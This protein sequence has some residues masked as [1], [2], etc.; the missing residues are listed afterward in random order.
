LA[1]FGKKDN[2]KI[3]ISQIVYNGLPYI[4]LRQFFL[5]GSGEWL[6]T[7]KGLTLSPSKVKNLIDILQ[8]I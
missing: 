7:K 8:K 3:I 4:D 1:K 2:E 5:G 6:P